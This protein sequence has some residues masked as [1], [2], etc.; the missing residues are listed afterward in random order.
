MPYFV[1]ARPIRYVSAPRGLSGP[2]SPGQDVA[3][4]S[5]VRAMR[6][7]PFFAGLSGLRGP[8][9]FSGKRG[10]RTPLFSGLGCSCSECRTG[11]SWLGQG[12]GIDTVDTGISTTLVPDT[13]DITPLMNT[14]PTIFD[15]SPMLTESAGIPT[16]LT[17]PS[18][19]TSPMLTI[20]GVLPSTVGLLTNAG[21]KP[22]VVQLQRGVAA[23]SIIPGLSNTTLYIG[24]GALVLLAVLGGKR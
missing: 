12:D 19:G 6:L 24:A 2:A 1:P 3:N 21:Q 13:T 14:S 7:R 9:V 22:P 8:V 18:A 4:A 11:M 15:N 17:V 20:A 23:P 10:D 5:R 16:T